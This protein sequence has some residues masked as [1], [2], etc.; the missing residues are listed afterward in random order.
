MAGGSPHQVVSV[1]GGMG[2]GGGGSARCAGVLVERRVVG[3]CRVGLHG[4]DLGL[5]CREMSCYKGATVYDVGR[6]W[7][8]PKADERNKIS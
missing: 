1:H 2:G 6:G 3:D 5:E 8:P 7:G 4:C